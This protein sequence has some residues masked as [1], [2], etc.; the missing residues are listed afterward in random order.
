MY[1]RKL[2][3]LDGPLLNLRAQVVPPTSLMR[4]VEPTSHIFS[5]SP[6]SDCRL[7]PTTR[8]AGFPAVG[9]GIGSRDRLRAAT[10]ASRTQVKGLASDECIRALVVASPT[11][12]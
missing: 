3:P 11:S 7:W 4:R 5:V 6:T 9:W 8:Q 12:R 10:L 2:R 1:V